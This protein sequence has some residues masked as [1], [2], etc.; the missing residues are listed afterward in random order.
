[1]AV[2]YVWVTGFPQNLRVNRYYEKYYEPM[3]EKTVDRILK[4][5]GIG[6]S[7]EN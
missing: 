6:G 4:E 1:M 5:K 3:V 2:V 7:H